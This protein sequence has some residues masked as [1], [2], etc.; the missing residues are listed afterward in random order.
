VQARA[1][2]EQLLETA[3][4]AA[5]HIARM[6]FAWRAESADAARAAFARARRAPGVRWQVYAAA[7]QLEHT[8][9]IP[10]EATEVAGRIYRLAIQHFENE[11]HT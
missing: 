9:G 1:L 6:R 11:V 2:L 10:P 8:Y 7:A 3:P 4:H 5:C